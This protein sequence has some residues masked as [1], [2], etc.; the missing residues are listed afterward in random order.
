MKF[1]QHIFCL[2]IAALFSAGAEAAVT[3]ALDR[4]SVA[5]GETVELSLQHEGRTSSKPDFTPLQRDFDILGTSSGSSVQFVNGAMSAQAELRLT[6]APKHAGRLQIPALQWDGQSTAALALT[7][8]A[9]AGRDDAAGAEAGSSAAV[10]FTSSLSDKLPFVQS[11]VLL[12]LRLHIGT[13]LERASLDFTGNDGIAVQQL[14]KDVQSSETRNGHRYTVIQRQ[15]L[16]TPQQ[17]GELALD[18]PVLN[19]EAPDSRSND[20][21]GGAGF[22]SLFQ[23]MRPMHLRGEPLHF[24]VRPRPKTAAGRDWLP[25]EGLNLQAGLNPARGKLHAGEPLTLHL[26]LAATGISGAQLPDLGKL[27]VLPEGLKAYPDQ[28][29]IDTTVQDEK[30]VGSREQDIALI[31]TEP[32]NYELPELH[33]AWWDSRENVQREAVIPA[34]SI[35]ILPAVGGTAA[36]VTPR[37]ALSAPLPGASIA[38][39]PVPAVSA[40]AQPWFWLCLLFATLWL[41]TL[42]AWA[43][44]R[45][46]APKAVVAQAVDEQ[47]APALKAAAAVRAAR[48]AC[49]ANTPKPA[50]EALLAWARAH[51]R[52][53]P[54]SGLNA[55]AQRLDDAA[56]RALI[57]E[58]DR[59]CYAATAAWQGQALAA[60]LSRL[61]GK[62]GTAAPVPPALP[63]LYPG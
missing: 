22:G 31:A 57:Q 55:L 50:R 62:A 56:L 25:A 17:S 12:T 46:G 60:A 49:L 8:G 18:G 1:A 63:G 28:A 19:G 23:T 53:S 51:F 42:A 3:A 34:R 30:P 36:P 2:L 33:L 39:V 52:Q 13:Q 21:F 54:P 5:V 47:K 6:L 40:R 35:E 20:P 10:F 15:Y 41:G 37:P 48:E 24:S 14:G 32:G 7:V 4:D 26:S 58:L 29:K 27:L 43:L 45:K 59:A 9:A 16:L 61:P 38:P 11:A 44:R